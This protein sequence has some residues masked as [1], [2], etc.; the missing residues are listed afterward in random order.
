MKN[1]SMTPN[2]IDGDSVPFIVGDMLKRNYPLLDKLYRK[3]QQ[4]SKR[5]NRNVSSEHQ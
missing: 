2:T 3:Q 1:L 5:K 4:S